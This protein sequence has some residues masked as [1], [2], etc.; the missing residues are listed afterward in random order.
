VDWLPLIGGPEDMNP[1]LNEAVERMT[2]GARLL[3]NRA[4][5]AAAIAHFCRSIQG[6]NTVQQRRLSWSAE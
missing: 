5:W 4:R 2:A 1:V 6:P 3:R